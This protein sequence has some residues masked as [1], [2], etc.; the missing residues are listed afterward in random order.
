MTT[1]LCTDAYKF[2]M[3]SAGYPLRRETFYYA[4]R[5]GGWQYL[6]VDVEAFI[7]ENL[8]ARVSELSTEDRDFLKSYGYFVDDATSA[9]FGSVLEVEALPRGSWFYDREPVFSVTGPSALVSWREPLILQLNYRIQAATT[10]LLDTDRFHE[11]TPALTCDRERE[12]VEETLDAIGMEGPNFT[13]DTAGYQRAVV[14]RARELV[15]IVGDTGRIFEVGLRA[16]SCVEQHE[17]A[18]EV[19]RE[20]G[21]TRTSNAA[22]ARKLAMVP[23]GTM[24]HEHIQRHGSDYAAFTAM[25]DRVRGFKFYLPDTFDTMASGIPAAIAAMQETGLTGGIRFD[26]EHG[27]VGHYLYAVNRARE[28]GITPV[29]ALESGWNAELTRKF[30]GLREACG[31]SAES[32]RYGFGGYLVRPP[33]AHFGRDDVSAVWKISQTGSRATMKFG[34]EPMG[35]KSSIPGKP[36]VWRPRLGSADHRGPVGYIAQMGED[37]APPD[38]AVRLSGAGKVPQEVRFSAREIRDFTN[39]G[40]APAA[41]SP[42]TRALIERCTAERDEGIARALSLS[43]RS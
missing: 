36:V 35:G 19:I 21:I 34:D 13:V 39:R 42:A 3:A 28:A 11:R 33:W 7:R 41:L 15:S 17:L 16:V 2:S 27:I 4:H 8:P 29:L 9:A 43:R 30:E 26:S 14:N 10:A 5:K 32:Q 1:V 20:A 31:W 22:G 37:W 23:V 25:R 6:P 40:F 12:I 18:L 24:G 38:G